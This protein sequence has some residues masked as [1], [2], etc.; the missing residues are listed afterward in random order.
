MPIF[1]IKD[2]KVR[3]VSSNVDH[4][5][6]EAALRDFFAENLEQLLGMRFLANEYSTSDGRIDTLALD[7]NNFPVIIEYKWGQDNAIVVQG[8]FYYDWLKKNKKHFGLLVSDKL[9]KDAVVAWERPRVV[10]VSQGFDNRTLVAVQQLECVELIRYTPYNHD[11]L[12][13]ENVYSPKAI[14]TFKESPKGNETEEDSAEGGPYDIDYHLQRN[15]TEKEIVEA[16]H[17]LQERIK[18]LPGVEEF[19]DQKTGIT[20]RTT[21][22][23]VRFEFR[24]T[25]M[26]ILLKEPTYNDPEGLVK[27]ITTHMWGYKGMIKID[28]SKHIDAVFNLIMQSYQS[29]L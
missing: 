10:L 18:S 20:Y 7:D 23:F 5:K 11:I 3:Q 27:D 13:L 1:Q 24:K 19:I 2:N 14:K 16:F 4:F 28:S 29:T 21:K 12:Y 8:L 15:K 17:M 26:S 22:S 9:G 6:N 25:S